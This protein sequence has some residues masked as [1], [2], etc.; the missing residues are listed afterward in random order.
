MEQNA[1][2]I[3]PRATIHI[4]DTLILVNGQD[5]GFSAHRPPPSA[6]TARPH[7]GGIVTPQENSPEQIGRQGVRGIPHQ[8]GQD[9]KGARFIEALGPIV[10]K[11]LC[12]LLQLAVTAEEEQVLPSAANHLSLYRRLLL[13]IGIRVCSASIQ[14]IK[15]I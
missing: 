10:K 7:K 1:V 5:C 2:P 11:Q 13:L 6:N 8:H 9:S 14:D 4:Q 3:P 12:P 15:Y